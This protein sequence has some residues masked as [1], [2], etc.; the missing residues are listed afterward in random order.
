MG[1]EIASRQSPYRFWCQ[2]QIDN[3]K[4]DSTKRKQIRGI[5]PADALVAFKQYMH[6]LLMRKSSRQSKRLRF[7]NE[8]RILFVKRN[9]FTEEFASLSEELPPLQLRELILKGCKKLEWLPS[10]IR[11]LQHLKKV[12]AEFH[13]SSLSEVFCGLQSLECLQLQSPVLSSLPAGFGNLTTLR[14][15]NLGYCK[16]LS[17]LPESLSHLIHLEVLNLLSCEMLSSLPVGFGNLSNL[18]NINL[19]SCKKLKLLPDSFN[20]LTYLKILDLSQY[21]TL[22]S[23]PSSFGNLINLRDINIAHCKELEILPDSFK[24]LIHLEKIE[25]EE[26]PSFADLA[27]LNRFVMLDCPKVEKYKAIINSLEFPDLAVTEAE[28]PSDVDEIPYARGSEARM[29]MLCYVEKEE[30][31]EE[32]RRV[33]DICYLEGEFGPY[34]PQTKAKLVWGK[35][36]RVEEAFYQ[37]LQLME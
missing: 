19:A 22:S 13:C 25:I 23:L 9:E 26:F 8:L 12:V 10:S 32:E 15:I 6:R 30:E 14:N 18:M 17:I 28:R 5:Q 20:Q 21:K 34:F 27:S 36:G 24:H 29:R 33:I 3:L 35:R 11:H 7:S 4:K 31:N 37:L 16:Q 2:Q 1:R